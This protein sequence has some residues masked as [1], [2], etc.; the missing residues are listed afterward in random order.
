L[1]WCKRLPQLRVPGVT[2]ADVWRRCPA[3]WG[4]DDA[5]RPLIGHRHAF[6]LPA[7]EDGDGRMDHLTVFAPMGFSPLE[8]QALDRVRRLSF[9]NGDPLRLVLAGLGDSTGFHTP[10]LGESTT[11]LSA[12]PF[13]AT[14]Y[15]KLSGTKRDRPEDY[16]TPR[17]FTRH[18][19]EQELRRRPGLPR[20]VS[21]SEELI[22][23]HRLRPIQFKR[24]RSKAGDDGGRRPAGGFRITFESPVLGPLCIGHACHFGLGLFM[25]APAG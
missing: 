14:R 13:I 16:A 11:W 4:K 7:D 24:F 17:T 21:I 3:F 9:G 5:G 8:Q 2:D 10:I 12:T 22:G 18:V 20:V 23:T 25:P 19:L 15:P 1:W 6:F